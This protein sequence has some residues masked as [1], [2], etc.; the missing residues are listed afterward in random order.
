MEFAGYKEK[1]IN[2]T[3]MEKFEKDY[4]NKE[5]NKNSN[6]NEWRAICD[7]FMRKL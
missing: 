1:D 7:S 3:T 5:E 6:F 4:F 2:K